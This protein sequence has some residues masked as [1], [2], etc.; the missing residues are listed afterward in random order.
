MTF[1]PRR[2]ALPGLVG[3]LVLACA[4][5][6]PTGCGTPTDPGAP[7][8]PEAGAPE[9]V[10]A[11]FD[12][13]DGTPC[14]GNKLCVHG[15]C[16]EPICG[17]GIVTAPEECDRGVLN[18]PGSGCETSCKLTCVGSDPSRN[19]AVAEGCLASGVCDETT[20]T[21]K[22]GGPK[23]TGS[24]CGPSKYCKGSE[25]VDG[26]CGDAVVTSPEAC[27]NGDANGPKT[28]CEKNCTFSCSDPKVDCTAPP[29]C[30]LAACDADHRC[31][32]TPDVTKNGQGCGTGLV[33]NNGACIAPGATCGNGVL[34]GGEECDLGAGNGPGTGCETICKFSCTS[35]ASC[36]DNNACHAAPTCADVTVGGKAGKKC[37]PGATKADGAVCGIGSICLG[38][39]CKPSACG[40]GF[41]DDAAKEECDDGNITKLDACSNQCKF[42]QDHRV[43]T[44]RMQFDTDA[45]C[46]ANIVGKSIGGLAR[47]TFQDSI[48]STIKDGSVSPL[49]TLAGDLK[50]ATGAVSVGNLSGAPPSNAPPY[51]GTA[52]LDWW[53]TVNPTT[54]DANRNARATLT[55]TYANG[56]LNATGHLNLITSIGGAL[57]SLAVSSAKITMPIGGAT[58]PLTSANGSPP[59]HLAAEHLSSTIQSYERTGGTD[60]KNPTGQMCGNIAASSLENTVPP[61]NLLPGG[62]NACNEK[63]STANRLIDIIV[64]GCHV[65]ALNVTAIKPTQ[66]DQVDPDA[67]P[68]GAGGPYTLATDPTTKR[69][70][71]CRDKNNTVVTLQTC[72]NAAAY[73]MSFKFATDRVIIK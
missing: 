37:V 24:T 67:P 9:G 12:V 56:V 47:T 50:G 60:L 35:A 58:T 40:D 18:G 21:C 52:D 5:T 34:E 54:I 46:T 20:H 32:S 26:V 66:P 31:G 8:T 44:M 14:P 10:S 15:V 23:P 48:D 25:C 70:T 61:A 39:T 22:A 65:S 1:F 53:Y 57:A 68:A 55:G 11:C 62:D 6:A 19:C 63:Y 27:D 43:I 29:P 45:Y 33:C 16:S 17:D 38:G 13:A 28:G 49:F 30:N 64:K 72:L 3:I 36:I 69:V 7:E 42:E 73:S 51:N 4:A 59:G 71:T 41:R 2:V